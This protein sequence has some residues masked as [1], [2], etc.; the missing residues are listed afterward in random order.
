M[1]LPTALALLAALAAP[2]LA[3]AAELNKLH[4][5]LVI[6]TEAGLGEGVK[7]DL[8]RVAGGL[9]AL[10]PSSR[11]EISVVTGGS[12]TPA[13]V[14]EAVAAAKTGPA[15]ALFVYYSGHGVTID[16]KHYLWL[17][18]G[19]AGKLE[20]QTLLAEMGKT[21]PGLKVLA[22]DCC[23]NRVASKLPAEGQTRDLQPPAKASPTAGN[24]FFRARGTM[25][26]TAATLEE[27][28]GDDER[29][30]YFT[31]ALMAVLRDPKL[32]VKSWGEFSPLVQDKTGKVFNAV[33]KAGMIPQAR[34]VQKPTVVFNDTRPADA[35]EVVDN[36][37]PS[38]PQAVKGAAAGALAV[39]GLFNPTSNPV[40]FRYRWDGEGD[41]VTLSIKPQGDVC[42]SH[43]AA[44]PANLPKL[45]FQLDGRA[46]KMLAAKLWSGKGEPVA[47]NGKGYDVRP[48]AK[49]TRTRGVGSQA[50]APPGEQD[51]PLP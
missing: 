38:G 13:G 3:N 18:N 41:W 30:G 39:V 6:D 47:S 11:L 44:N 23:S 22:T 28:F 27:S 34:A 5:V 37:T 14:L 9:R 4:A 2:A 24:L 7:I 16:N 46:A 29:G 21:K 49:A 43:K 32:S 35:V 31:F 48:S 17:Q 15:D 1:R 25:D 36:P 51:E 40:K 19:K 26:M 10:V 8:R 20:R 45:E 42:L 33:Q 12:V 50:D